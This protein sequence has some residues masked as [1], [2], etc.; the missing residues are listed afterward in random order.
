MVG[1]V[2]FRTIGVHVISGTRSGSVYGVGGCTLSPMETVNLS[3]V[4]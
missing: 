2:A 3:G 4:V 1:L